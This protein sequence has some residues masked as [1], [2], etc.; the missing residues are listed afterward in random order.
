MREAPL[1]VTVKSMADHRPRARTYL[2]SLPETDRA[3]LLETGRSRRWQNGELLV[4]AGDRGDSA[5]V[6]LGGLVKIHK[7]AADGFEVVLGLAGAGDLLGEISAVRDAARS[8]SVTALEPVEGVVISVP[9][10]RTFL[11]QHPRASLAMLELAISRLYEADT[12][13][14]EFATYE[15]LARVASRLVELAERFGAPRPGGGID[16]R[17]PI[18]QEELASWSA[19]SREST[20]RALRTLR[21]L[22]LIETQRLKLLVLDLD[23]LRAHA[24]RP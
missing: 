23:G 9:S 16:L 20:A 19:T 14:V 13:R 24:A 21:G 15:S 10:L 8:A 5:I 3:D 7:S 2:D 12:H 1:V 11:N 4:R 17:L 6:L 22:G 18:T